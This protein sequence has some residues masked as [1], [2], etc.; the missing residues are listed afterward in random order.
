MNKIFYLKA[1]T[2][3]VLLLTVTAACS[4]APFHLIDP[5]QKK[6][7]LSNNWVFSD[8]VRVA[9]SDPLVG[10]IS[11]SNDAT[12]AATTN[13][14]SKEGTSSSTVTDISKDSDREPSKSETGNI[15]SESEKAP[16]AGVDLASENESVSGSIGSESNP[17]KDSGSGNIGSHLES[18]S[19]SETDSGAGAG[20]GSDSGSGSINSGSQTSISVG[21]ICGN[22]LTT[23]AGGNLKTFQGSY[24]V[25]LLELNSGKVLCERSGSDIRE[26]LLNEKKLLL[27]TNCPIVNTKLKFTLQVVADQP[28]N[29]QTNKNGTNIKPPNPFSNGAERSSNFSN[30][31]ISAGV[32]SFLSSQKNQLLYFSNEA[33]VYAI[34]MDQLLQTTQS[35]VA[36]TS[37]STAA[38]KALKKLNQTTQETPIYVL[39]DKR[40]TTQP[41]DRLSASPLFVDMGLRGGQ[42]ELTP[43]TQGVQF[44]ILGQNAKPVAHSKKQISWFK[45]ANYMFLVKPNERGQVLGV[46]EMFG[47][48]TLGPDGKMATDG[49]HAFAKY[50]SNRD[51]VIDENDPVFKNLRLWSDLNLDGVAEPGELFLLDF[52]G[53][54]M[55]DLRYNPKYYERD[56][57]GNEIVYKSVVKMKDN[58]LRLIFDLWFRYL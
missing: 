7:F 33:P 21:Y 51:S 8:K 30:Q 13:S 25:R 54:E 2:S 28:T 17:E 27:P 22:H 48:N 44:D 29:N 9:A 37:S 52:M 32:A 19:G 53:V 24:T 46:N 23:Q 57:Y 1:I 35:S 41:C 5:K 36:A 15:G 26:A 38:S 3:G 10:S 43:I 58:S 18:G 16:E 4:R 42:T 56:K 47:D 14:D 6:E 45:D 50:D 12:G 34:T 39:Y 31:F 49:F 11:S 55:I 40:D 20:S